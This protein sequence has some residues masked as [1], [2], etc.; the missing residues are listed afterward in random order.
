[1]IFHKNYGGDSIVLKIYLFFGIVI[2]VVI[3]V[4]TDMLKFQYNSCKY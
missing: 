2:P 1:M 4:V 3:S